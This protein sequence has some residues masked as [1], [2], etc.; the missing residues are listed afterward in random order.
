MQ[1]GK[2]YILRL[3]SGNY[4]VGKTSDVQRRWL[5]HKAG[6][7]AIICRKDPP[8]EKAYE[9]DTEETND[10]IVL[11]LEDL[12]T[13]SLMIQLGAS[14]VTGGRYITTDYRRASNDW[15]KAEEDRIRLC[16]EYHNKGFEKILGRVYNA[17]IFCK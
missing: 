14:R 9:F 13:L 11:Y 17:I 2:I 5:E 15:I 6:T 1:T 3:K 8:I 12:T 4:Y 7:G 16:L 10:K